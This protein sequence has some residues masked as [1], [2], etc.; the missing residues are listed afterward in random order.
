MLGTVTVL[1]MGAMLPQSGPELPLRRGI[2]IDRQFHEIPPVPERTVHAEDVRT[3][4]RLG[5][6]FVKLIVNPAVLQ[7]ADGSLD[8]TRTWYFERIIGYGV[9]EKLPVVLC[10]HPE[11]PA[12]EKALADPAKFAEF[13]RWE[14]ELAHWIAGHWD[15]KTL[16]LQL[17]T[18]PPPS[19]TDPA[20]WNYWGTLQTRLWEAARQEL[21][22]HTLILSGDMGGSIE[23]LEHV[24]LVNDE[25]VLYSFTFYEPNLFAWQGDTGS[26]LMQCLKG[27]PWPSGPETLEALP[28]IL[29]GVPEDLKA[30]VKR[31][32]E[33]YA[34]QKWDEAKVAERIGRLAD[35]RARQGGKPKLWCAEFGCHQ[36]APEAQ[37]LRYIELMRELFDRYDIGWAYWSFNENYS[38]MTADRVPSGPA[39]EQRVDEAL[40][41]ALM[42]GR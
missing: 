41:R 40:L 12:K 20:A 18:E 3:I 9:S 42:P 2:T 25:N 24:K 19:S 21:P 17:M 8:T 6:D 15:E 27:I 14:R 10:V 35:W 31:R 39:L 22:R 26:R 5:F 16:A 36:G 1:L 13:L 34:S 37:R 29:E 11:W 23:G 32:V 33:G 38:I 30:D 28:R 7:A 4:K